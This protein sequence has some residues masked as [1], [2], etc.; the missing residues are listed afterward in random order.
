M[1]RVSNI[2]V[3]LEER[4][5]VLPPLLK[6]LRLKRAELTQ[7][8]IFREAIDARRKA[9]IHFVY[10]VD[11]TVQDEHK[12][13][14]STTDA[15]ISLTPELAYHLPGLG[16]SPLKHRPVIVGSGPAGLFAGL[17]LSELGFRPLIL[18]RGDDVD[19][20]AAKVSHFWRGGAL[21]TESNVQFGE[22]GAG[23][24]SDGK[25]TTNI[26]DSRCR[27]VLTELVAAGAPGDILYSYKPHVGTDILRVVVKGL[28]QTITA[29][30]GEIRFLAHVTDLCVDR[31][32]V[33]G[34]VIN[35]KEKISA[36]V[37]LVAPGH[38][39]RDTFALLLARGVYMAAKPFAIG[40]RIEHR[41]TMIDEAQYGRAAG[42]PNL[43]AADY[44]LSHHV[45]SGRSVYTFCM[46]PGGQVVAAASEQGGVV[47]NGMSEHA[48]ASGY[49]NSAV[50][51]EVNPTDFGSTHPLA[52]AFFQRYIE[53]RAWELGG[54]SHRA[55]AQTVGDF[56]IGQKSAKLSGMP[57][58]YLPGVEPSDLSECLPDYV[59]ASMRNG[60]RAFDRKLRG[61]A[62]A[63]AVLTGVETRSSSPVK[64]IRREDGQSSIAGLY[65]A[66]EGAGYAG[67]I[68][69]AA[70]DGLRVAEGIASK[71]RGL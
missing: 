70:V 30:G 61:F 57:P 19:R 49:A 12:L 46:C 11:V 28:R 56:L 67:G 15:D 8:R 18:E 7:V 1:I 6:K 21:D 23:T 50:L 52:G 53:A 35:S 27:K 20:R 31:G 5:E 64:M 51:V 54:R 71:Y 40:A 22:G 58:S 36:E 32:A 47:T 37:V 10:T 14:Q 24:F 3:P 48:R 9:S 65:V 55:P 59:V 60:L 63:S 39:A 38:S 33:A 41:Q 4:G 45:E 44:K 68:V 43:G 29:R 66:G 26:K 69:S 34:V 2:K 17:L 16:M 62:D 25:L 42:H 13:L